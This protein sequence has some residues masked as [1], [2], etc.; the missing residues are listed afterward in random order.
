[1]DLKPYSH[2]NFTLIKYS[3]EHYLEFAI[4]KP[5]IYCNNIKNLFKIIPSLT[6]V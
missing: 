4:I 1:M 5:E 6:E 2:Q 3:T